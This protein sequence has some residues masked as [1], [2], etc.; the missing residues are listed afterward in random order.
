MYLGQYLI[1]KKLVNEKDVL[2]S[3]LEQVESS[4]SVL[5]IISDLNLVPPAVLIGIV[6]A[7]IKAQKS[8]SQILLEKKLISTQDFEKVL[9][10]QARQ[11][12]TLS[13]IIVEKK[14]LNHEDC[15]AAIEESQVL[16]SSSAS[17]ESEGDVKTD[18]SSAED[19][20][21]EE[22]SWAALETLKETGAVPEEE[23]KRLEAKLKKKSEVEQPPAI[24]EKSS[25]MTLDLFTTEFVTLLNENRVQELKEK[26]NLLEVDG[27]DSIDQI[28][29]E[30]H[31]LTGAAKM[32]GLQLFAKLF[33]SWEKVIESMKKTQRLDHSLISEGHFML[34]LAF[35]LRNGLIDFGKESVLLNKLQLKEKYLDNM[36]KAILIV[37]KAG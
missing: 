2:S 17:S 10:E 8:V 30:L 13:E 19:G 27:L 26:L 34:D 7:S 6:D 28:F 1:E 31:L 33:E 3:V 9:S 22:I 4:P 25:E 37:K 32:A 21:D 11:T 16:D 14:L 20:D 36:K 23:I 15:Q 29:N 24:E 5:R 35:S 18:V 12:R